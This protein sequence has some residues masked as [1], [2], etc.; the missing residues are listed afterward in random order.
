VE[1]VGNLS[2]DAR[3]IDGVYGRKPMGFVDL[4]ISKERFHEILHSA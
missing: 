4:G 1:V 2:Q 3:P